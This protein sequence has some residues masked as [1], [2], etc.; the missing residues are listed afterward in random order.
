MYAVFRL[1]F[2][3]LLILGFRTVPR[4]IH[5]EAGSDCIDVE[6]RCT[7]EE[8]HSGAIKAVKVER[9]RFDAHNRSYITLAFRFSA[10][11]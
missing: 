6:L 1:R 2:E 8:L 5:R 3:W 4:T 10:D 9:Q 11:V 7:L